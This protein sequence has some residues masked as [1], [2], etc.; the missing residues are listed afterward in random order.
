MGA[1]M[2]IFLGF[3][4]IGQSGT[5]DYEINDPIFLEE[6]DLGTELVTLLCL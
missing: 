5:L 4:D 2:S 1:S 3:F 6:I